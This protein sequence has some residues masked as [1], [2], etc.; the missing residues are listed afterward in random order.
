[1]AASYCHVLSTVPLLSPNQAILKQNASSDLFTSP[2]LAAHA[3]MV[4]MGATIL[5]LTY[6]HQQDANRPQDMAL[7]AVTT[8]CVEHN[9]KFC[10]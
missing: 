4:S 2:V 8:K 6:R 7:P 1:M 10:M 3:Q 9:L 5:P